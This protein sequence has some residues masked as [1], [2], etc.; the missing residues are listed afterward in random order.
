MA[1]KTKVPKKKTRTKQTIAKSKKPVT[2]RK[3]RTP[4]KVAKRSGKKFPAAFSTA[5]AVQGIAEVSFAEVTGACR[6]TDTDGRRVCEDGVTQADCAGRKN[7][8]WIP[9]GRCS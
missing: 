7:S 9:H 8:T 3:K 1:R 2:T 5:K 6:W 4:K